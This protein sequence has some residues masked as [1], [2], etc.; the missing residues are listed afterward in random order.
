MGPEST[1]W[2]L[3]QRF[4]KTRIQRGRGWGWGVELGQ[5]GGS[6]PVSCRACFTYEET[7][8]HECVHSWHSEN[9]LFSIYSLWRCG[10]GSCHSVLPVTEV[11][12]S[13]VA[14]NHRAFTSERSL[15]AHPRVQK[16]ILTAAGDSPGWQKALRNPATQLW[17]IWSSTTTVINPR[18]L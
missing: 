13:T 10:L 9:T 14:F 1:S 4:C 18:C 17:I 7:V 16:V 3:F 5:Q 12:N 8:E 2:R 11:K 6:V 15:H